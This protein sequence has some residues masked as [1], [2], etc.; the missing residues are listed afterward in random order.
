M[1]YLGLAIYL[2]VILALGSGVYASYQ[3]IKNHQISESVIV[4]NKVLVLVNNLNKKYEYFN[5]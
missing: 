3:K 5:N 4:L 1:K 2:M